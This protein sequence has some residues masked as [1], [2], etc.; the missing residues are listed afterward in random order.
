MLAGLLSV[1][2]ECCTS[3]EPAYG[4][5]KARLASAGLDLDVHRRET[6]LI[7]A[8]LSQRAILGLPTTSCLACRAGLRRACSSPRRPQSAFFKVECRRWARSATTA[9]VTSMIKKDERWVVT[10]WDWSVA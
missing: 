3:S 8:W 6:N 10:K 1:S 9:G 2:D 4:Q 7:P 5:G